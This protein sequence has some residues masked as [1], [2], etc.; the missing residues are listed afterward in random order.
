MR[1]ASKKDA[2]VDELGPAT[3]KWDYLDEAGHLIAVVYRYDPPGQKKQ[4]RPWDAKRRK[5]APPEPRPLYNQPGI[6]AAE[7][8]ILVEGEKCAQALIEAGISATTAMHGA[9]APVDKTDWSPLAGKAVLIWPDRD[10][11]GFGYAEAASQAVLMA[12]ATSCAILLP[13]DAKPEGW[14]AAD[15]LAAPFGLDVE[16]GE[17]RGEI[18]ARVQVVDL[19]AD[20]AD[21]FVPGK[22]EQGQRDGALARTFGDPAF[23]FGEVVPRVEVGPFVMEP[24][25]KLR[26]LFAMLSQ[27]SDTDAHDMKLPVRA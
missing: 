15:A 5:M 10:K 18:G 25:R 6:A 9:N 16:A 14:D 3:A 21:Q 2:P 7:Q 19:E 20:G 1:K 4:F 12:G 24:A 23:D 22:S 11:P 13:P 17:P 8:V 27:V 26:D